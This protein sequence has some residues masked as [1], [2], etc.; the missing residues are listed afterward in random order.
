MTDARREAQIAWMA[1]GSANLIKSVDILKKRE[2]WKYDL[3]RTILERN[4]RK[5][6]FEYP[7]G[8]FVF[9][10]ALLDANILVEFDGEYHSGAAQRERDQRKDAVAKE[11]GFIVVRRPVVRST[12]IDPI[13]LDGL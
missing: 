8:N 2:A 9:D 5:F 11:H 4:G 1:A 13:T 12:V 10:L 7:I 6:E 3:L